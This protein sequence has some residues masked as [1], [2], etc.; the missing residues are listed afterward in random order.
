MLKKCDVL[1]KEEKDNDKKI[2][3]VLF[4]ID[5]L[6]FFVIGGEEKIKELALRMK[7]IIKEKFNI[8]SKILFKKVEKVEKDKTLDEITD[9]INN[10]IKD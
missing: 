8:D 10:A 2:L 5:A 4:S 7:D 3:N 6:D 9:A 1:L